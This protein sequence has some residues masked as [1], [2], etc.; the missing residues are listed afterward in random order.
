M[1]CLLGDLYECISG[2]CQEQKTMTHVRWRLACWGP[3]R[4]PLMC[5]NPHI[6]LNR[7]PAQ[8]ERWAAQSFNNSRHLTRSPKHAD[9]QGGFVEG[10]QHSHAWFVLAA[11]C[12][13]CIR[14]TPDIR[15]VETAFEA[16]GT[17]K[18][19]RGTQAPATASRAA[20]PPP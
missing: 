7:E 15:P 8:K 5:S 3:G 10:G 9:I 2:G 14:H 16:D 18:S 6:E 11:V 12:P 13:T 17:H 4:S 19:D 1:P 20:R